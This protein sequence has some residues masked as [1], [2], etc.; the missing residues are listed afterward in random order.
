MSTPQKN[1]HE[2]VKKKLKIIGF[3]LLA[4][5]FVLTVIGFISFFSSMGSFAPPKFFWCAFLGLPLLGFGAMITSMAFRRELSKYAKDEMMPV[6]KEAGK[7]I[8][9]TVQDLAAAVKRGLEDEG[10]GDKSNICPVCGNG[11]DAADKF[12]GTCG[13]SLAEICP[14][15]GYENP[16]SDKFCGHCGQEL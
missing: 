13:S 6:V 9:P 1:D 2:S 10:E 14:K 3:S 15:C 16:S 8:A 11:N 12:C 4:V 7:E 5:G